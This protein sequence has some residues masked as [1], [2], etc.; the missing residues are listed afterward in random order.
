MSTKK[1]T[2]KRCAS[3]SKT[4]PKAKRTGNMFTREI[5]TLAIAARH[6]FDYQESLGNIEDGVT[7]DVW[8]REQVMEAV[9]KPG[10]SALFHADFRPVLA[11][12][13]LLAGSD[14]KALDL[15]LK[16]GKAKDH[17]AA[18][19]THEKREQV[20][21][22]I[23]D[24]LKRHVDLATFVGTIHD[25]RLSRARAAIDTHG[26]H[27]NEGYVIS[28]VRAKSRTQLRNLDQLAERLTLK[29]LN[30]LL[31]TVRNR[32]STR[33]GRANDDLRRQNRQAKK[34]RADANPEPP[35]DRQF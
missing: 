28:I 9:G 27:I 32:I 20:A 2:T 24:E 25:E 18:E 11:H 17:G 21:H 16:T 13:Q 7:F 19:D 1:V 29:Q 26:S 6:A 35:S 22:L 5:Q 3:G 23:R 31:S 33:E 34:R 14:E 10:L 30:D 8:R 4:K 12:F 15:F